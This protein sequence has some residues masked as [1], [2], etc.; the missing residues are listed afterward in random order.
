MRI[1]TRL[2]SRP[3]GRVPIRLVIKIRNDDRAKYLRGSTVEQGG[4]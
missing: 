2:T 1:S 4:P 3:E